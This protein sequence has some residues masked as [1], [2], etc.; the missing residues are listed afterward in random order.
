MSNDPSASFP[1]LR[2]AVRNKEDFDDA[3]RLVLAAKDGASIRKSE[4]DR[5]KGVLSRAAESAWEAYVTET[6]FH[7]GKWADQDTAARDLNDRVMIMSL[8]DVLAASKKVAASESESPPVLAMR[9]YCAEVAPL[10]HLMA[11][12]KSVV[13]SGRASRET[14]APTPARVN[15]AGTCACCFRDIAVVRGT[16][17]HHGYQRPQLGFQTASCPGVRFR[18]LEVSSEGLVWLINYL[19]GESE[20]SR[21]QL[22]DRDSWS[23]ITRLARAPA[24]GRSRTHLITTRRDDPKWP[25]EF[26]RRVD[27][28][29]SEIKATEAHIAELEPVLAAWKP[30]AWLDSPSEPEPPQDDDDEC[31]GP[32]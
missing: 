23:A 12:L 19:R 10:A 17:A 7:A 30:S 24:G 20:K 27:T 26:Q 9:E 18:P 8:H 13:V 1:I 6:F 16:M 5:A 21:E 11:S 29:T 22:A 14:P 15:D 2:A 28:L 3:I 31:S 32:R 25:A 4:Y